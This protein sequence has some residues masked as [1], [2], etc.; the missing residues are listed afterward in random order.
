MATAVKI[1]Q[2]EKGRDG[3]SFDNYCY[4]FDKRLADRSRTW[5]C[6]ERRACNER[7]LTCDDFSNPVLRTP[8]D[9]TIRHCYEEAMLRDVRTKQRQ[10]AAMEDTP[11][12]AIY[13][14]ETQIFAHNPTTAAVM[15]SFVKANIT[16]Y[17]NR[18]AELP[19]L[20]ASRQ[21]IQVPQLLQTTT[22]GQQFLQYCASGNEFIILVSQADLTN[23]SQEISMDGTF[24]TSRPLFM[25][26][27]TIHGDVADIQM[28]MVFVLMAAKTSQMYSDVFRQLKILCQQQ[29]GQQ[30][31]PLLI[32]SD[33]NPV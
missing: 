30:L 5:R 21:G 9:L 1:F 25:Q 32:M 4:R 27:F 2:T 28:P 26:L 31:Q 19:A 10:R 24:D 23:S 20:P 16:M 18:L 3:I 14:Q 12:P 11:T 22:D 6:I 29:F 8:H 15:P 33:T 13:R 17:R 7:L